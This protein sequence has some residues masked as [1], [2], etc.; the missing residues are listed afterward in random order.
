MTGGVRLGMLR[1]GAFWLVACG[2]AS[3]TGGGGGAAGTASAGTSAGGAGSA[4]TPAMA[5]AVDGGGTDNSG[6][7]N[8]GAD[9]GGGTDGK[10]TVDSD[11]T[12]CVFVTEP[13]QTT[14]C[15]CICTGQQR[16]LSVA[17]CD[18]NEAAWRA[19]CTEASKA[20]DC[21]ITGCP[22][23]RVVCKAEMCTD[24]LAP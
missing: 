11:C 10:C 3:V 5:G 17:A 8:G 13:R 2:G 21:P 16:A 12:P 18:L 23:R 7:D 6:T 15:Y 1:F 9:N 19:V 4:G 24:E 22:V 20:M 14:D